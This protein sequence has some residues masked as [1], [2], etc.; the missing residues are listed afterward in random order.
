VPT[1]PWDVRIARRLIRPLCGTRVRPN[2]VTTLGLLVGLGAAG[3][4]AA[5][6]ATAPHVAAALL[7]LTA[8]LDHADGEL[9]RATGT[10]SAFGHRYDRIADL[11][12]KIAV[13]TGMG[14]GLRHGPGGTWAVVLGAAAGVAVVTIFVCRTGIGALRGDAALRQ[15]AFAGFELED[16]LYLI[17]PAF[18]WLGHLRTFVLCAG[19]GAPLFAL[20][21][22]WQYWGA[23][24]PVSQTRGS[25]RPSSQRMTSSDVARSDR[26]GPARRWS[27]SPGSTTRS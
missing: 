4:F 19:V 17:V 10:A 6:G 16:V 18:T 27:D 24:S 1:T 12:V 11:V 7:V 14:F 9:A 15:P 23:R 8:V 13:F 22:A 21:I 26:P 2:H 20:L 3:L 25:V 5:G